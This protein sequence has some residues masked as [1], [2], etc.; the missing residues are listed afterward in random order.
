MARGAGHI[1]NPKCY[2]SRAPEL[3]GGCKTV[4]NNQISNDAPLLREL[5][6]KPMAGAG[7]CLNTKKRPRVGIMADESRQYNPTIHGHEVPMIIE[8]RPEIEDSAISE[9]S[10]VGACRFFDDRMEFIARNYPD[11][12]VTL[13]RL[14]LGAFVMSYTRRVDVVSMAYLL[15]L[16]S[17][18]TLLELRI[19]SLS[20]YEGGFYEP[21][22]DT[23]PESV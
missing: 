9:K 6:G 3:A 1:E 21:I 17:G 16:A 2:P 22:G 18:N 12:P 7:K 19:G 15:H 4:G 11:W 23:A 14:A 10:P 20:V 13:R 5:E 8:G